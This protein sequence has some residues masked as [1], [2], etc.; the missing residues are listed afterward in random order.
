[1][2]DLAEFLAAP[3]LARGVCRS[4]AAL[5]YGALTEFTLRSG[6]R[7]DV[8][9][10]NKAGEVVIVEI[11]TSEADFRADRKW[12]EYLGFCDSFYFAVPEGFPTR[13]LPESCGLILADAYGGVF[14]RTAPALSL[15]N[16]S[17]RRAL[18]L[19]FGL[20]ASGRLQ[21]VTDPESAL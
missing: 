20:A 12:P 2:M 5:G 17:R 16:G 1:M 3:R 14:L 10:M 7:A 9:G 8:I 15:M 11:K 19:R 21:R 13:I 4:L 6:R 18:T